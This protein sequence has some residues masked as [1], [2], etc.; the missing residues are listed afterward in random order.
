MASCGASAI[1]EKYDDGNQPTTEP[2]DK[3]RKRNLSV[4]IAFSYFS[5]T[6][7]SLWIK[8]CL[9][10]YI[11]IISRGNP[12]VLGW[13]TSLMGVSQLVSSLVSG[14]VADQRCIGR[15][16]VLRFA[17]LLGVPT[18][19]VTAW[20]ARTE[21][22]SFVAVA[23]TLWGIY[24]GALVPPT[25]ALLVD[26]TGA[27]EERSKWITRRFIAK[28]YGQASGPA[29]ALALFLLRGDEWTAHDCAFVIGAGQVVSFFAAILLC[30][31]RDNHR[32]EIVIESDRCGWLE[33]GFNNCYGGLIGM[34]RLIQSFKRKHGATVA[35][36]N[37]KIFE[38]T[39]LLL[40]D[41]ADNYV[42][43]DEDRPMYDSNS[44]DSD[45]VS[46]DSYRPVTESATNSQK[47]AKTIVL[48]DISLAIAEGMT[49]RFFP[50]FFIDLLGFRPVQLFPLYIVSH[51]LQAEVAK[52]LRVLGHRYGR[53]QTS[54]VGRLVSALALLGI[55]L[56]Y[57]L[58]LPSMITCVVYIVHMC[59]LNSPKP[60]TKGVLMDNVPE[61]ERARWNALESVNQFSWSGSAILGSIIVNRWGIVWNFVTTALLQFA[62]AIPLLLLFNLE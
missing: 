34:R 43:F 62:A 56:S 44:P 10:I 35:E 2:A 3:L 1:N 60:L 17:I 57:K 12:L 33:G 28:K 19:F 27:G 36:K 37:C 47:I 58:R 24:W 18:F 46:R 50:L 30:W 48:A 4:I 23:L 9:A 8:S 32:D 14:Y 31:L 7:R 53:I 52:L 22:V 45:D 20:A 42:T 15:E 26:S 6:G 5:L 59:A 54:F 61:N 11:H 16:G 40:E 13:L 49:V 25:G 51:L 55:S 29:T 38:Q 39:P 41:V 21:Q